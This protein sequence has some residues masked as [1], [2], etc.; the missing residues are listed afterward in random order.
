MEEILFFYKE[1]GLDIPN[2]KMKLTK[3]FV[4]KDGDTQ[5]WEIRGLWQ[6][7]NEEILQKCRKA[8]KF[9]EL[10]IDMEKYE[11]MVLAECVVFPDLHNAELQDSYGVA[12]SHALLIEMLTA[13]EYEVLKRAV[14]DI[15][16]G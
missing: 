14:E 9:G 3:R 5:E 10:F 15:N 7:E 2:R 13:G 16:M 12:G 1:N 8:G 4:G 11:A 6:K